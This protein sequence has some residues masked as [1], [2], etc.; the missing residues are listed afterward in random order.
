[1]SIQVCEVFA[2]PFPFVLEAEFSLRSDWLSVQSGQAK[3]GTVLPFGPALPEFL[4]FHL[5]IGQESV[6]LRQIEHVPNPDHCRHDIHWACA[7]EKAI[8]QLTRNNGL[9]WQLSRS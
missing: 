7:S 2:N 5:R 8:D 6:F 4:R 1:M 3:F 9:F